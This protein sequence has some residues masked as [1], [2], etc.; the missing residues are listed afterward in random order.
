MRY[1]MVRLARR[2]EIFGSRQ[3]AVALDVT[4]APTPLPAALPL[5]AGG[6]GL[7]GLFARRKKQGAFDAFAT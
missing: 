7:L 3:N 6:L 2:N 5:F 4:L 1:P